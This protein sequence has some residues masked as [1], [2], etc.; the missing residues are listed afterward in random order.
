MITIATRLAAGA[1]LLVA[2]TPAFALQ[3]G[4]PFADIAPIG[5][6]FLRDMR[7][8]MM[9]G[10]IPID[11]AVVVSTTVQGATLPMSGLQTTL[12][13]NDAGG[14]G[15]AHT[16]PIGAA[17]TAVAATGGFGL[18]LP[19]GQTSIIQQVVRDQIQTLIA[20]TAAGVAITHATTFDVT[21]PSFL[22]AS[23]GFAANAMIARMGI[24]AAV[25]GVRR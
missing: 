22:N 17:S 3:A 6:D 7:G 11:F 9:I 21:L 19:V 13:I 20:N 24:D 23:R 8:G 10:G 12:A 1:A 15:A 18:A 14:I 16:T 4:D 5:R 25:A 2:A